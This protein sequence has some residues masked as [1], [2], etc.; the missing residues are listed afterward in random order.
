MTTTLPEATTCGDC[1]DYG[2]TRRSLLQKAAI[3][4]AAGAVTSVFGDAVTQT[5]FGA[6][7][8]RQ[9]VLL[10]LS[11]RGG[12]DGLSMV[13]PHAEEAYNKTRPNLALKA[14]E[15]IEANQTF[16][17]HPKFEALR[18][19]WRSGKMAAIQAV[20]MQVPNRSHFE[21]ME[22]IEDADP[23]SSARVGWINRM[24]GSLSGTDPFEGLHLSGNQAPTALYGPQP[25]VA[26]NDLGAL[27]IPFGDDAWMRTRLQSG[28]TS[29][30]GGSSSAAL[31][32]A[33]GTALNVA[34]RARALGASKESKPANGAVYSTDDLGRSLA[35]AA[36]VVRSG[37]GARAI[38]IDYGSW[39]HHEGAPWRLSSMIE[40]LA[41]NLAAFFTDLGA[42]GDLVTV[43]TL[44][45]FGRR[46]AQNGSYG[47]DHGYGN[48]VLALG[49]GVKGGYYGKMPSLGTAAKPA[50]D[51]LVTTDYRHVL[52][53]VL[54]QRFPDV[55]LPSVF[56]GAAYGEDKRVGFM[57]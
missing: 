39:D 55:S 40:N 17:L 24:I 3:A 53:E 25:I 42:D 37:M 50:D 22:L 8:G 56:P 28:L 27:D 35:R 43:V 33:G 46:L 6:S 26:T 52:G 14:S 18:P 48:C 29:M 34:K 44:S 13:V 12:A 57:V 54:A 21:A 47:L 38:S 5:V 31:G 11:L 1:G 49:A 16:G 2:L 45:E 15:L 23:T 10:L 7:T 30:Y 20:G 4:G 32:E 41:K 36:G 9:P 19:M 51:L